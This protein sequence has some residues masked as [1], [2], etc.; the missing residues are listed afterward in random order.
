MAEAKTR[1]IILS[2][3]DAADSKQPR[4]LIESGAAAETPVENS[5]L[6]SSADSQA[7]DDSDVEGDTNQPHFDEAAEC[8]R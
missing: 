4:G 7:Q 5:D 2:F 1:P 6:I 3:D 8:C